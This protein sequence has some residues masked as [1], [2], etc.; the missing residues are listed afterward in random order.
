MLGQ[1]LHHTLALIY[2]TQP[3]G[4]GPVFP[5]TLSTS[6]HK[7]PQLNS[8]QRLALTLGA[9]PLDDTTSACGLLS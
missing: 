1:S 6:H 2:Y 9:L 5:S 3:S 8:V 4:P 7:W